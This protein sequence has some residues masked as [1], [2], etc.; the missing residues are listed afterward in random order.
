[1]QINNINNGYSMNFGVLSPELQKNMWRAVKRNCPKRNC[2]K[3]YCN[4]NLEKLKIYRDYKYI[5]ENT[6]GDNH[7]FVEV[8]DKS[9]K[10]FIVEKIPCSFGYDLA[11]MWDITKA[12]DK[13]DKYKEIIK[14]FA[15]S[16]RNNDNDNTLSNI[17]SVL[18][19]IN[20]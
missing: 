2:P 13:K 10:K 9:K 8:S 7:I 4:K 14:I 6:K 1:M 19:K 20:K 5:L 3:S 18:P 17:V 15:K 16:L 12:Y 11:N